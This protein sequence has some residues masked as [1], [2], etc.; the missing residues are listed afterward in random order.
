MIR[1][2]FAAALGL[3]LLQQP[4]QQ[5]VAPTNVISPITPPKVL[6]SDG[7]V[8][9]VCK[10]LAPA[11]V[12]V[13]LTVTTDGVAKDVKVLSSPTDAH[14]TCAVALINSYKF[15]PAMQDGQAVEIRLVLTMNVKSG[16]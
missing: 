14:G 13:Q 12:K 9:A 6:S 16:S 1:I 5:P 11:D 8:P 4:Q 15:L 10:D 7:P 2:A 3:G